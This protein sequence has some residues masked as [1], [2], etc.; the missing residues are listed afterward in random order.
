LDCFVGEV[1]HIVRDVL[2]EQVS[3][4]A[5]NL[6]YYEANS[7]YRIFLQIAQHMRAQIA[8]QIN[9]EIALQVKAHVADQLKDHLPIPLEV[10]AQESKRQLV[11]VRWSLVNS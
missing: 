1:K 4:F 6:N 7:T 8:E 10:Q 9:T 2:K 3:L 11:E 5:F